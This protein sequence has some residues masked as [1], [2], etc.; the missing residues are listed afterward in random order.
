MF[1][2]RGDDNRL[3]VKQGQKEMHQFIFMP[4]FSGMF[5]IITMKL[6]HV[7]PHET[8][9]LPVDGLLLHFTLGSFLK[10]CQENSVLVK[11]GQKQWTLYK[12]TQID[13]RP[14][15]SYKLLNSRESCLLPRKY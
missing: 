1:L 4:E 2:I 6:F 12:E 13:N 9:Q 3:T 10:T 11:I 5:A 7:C 8:T 15:L 14:H